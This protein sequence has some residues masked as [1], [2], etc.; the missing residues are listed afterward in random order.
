MAGLVPQDTTGAAPDSATSIQSD[1]TARNTEI[2]GGPQAEQDVTAAADSLA[3]QVLDTAS[4]FAERPGQESDTIAQPDSTQTAVPDSIQL[5]IFDP[6]GE[7]LYGIKAELSEV[8]GWLAVIE[9]LADVLRRRLGEPSEEIEASAGA[10]A[11]LS[12]SPEAIAAYDQARLHLFAARWAQAIRAARAATRHDST[13]AAAYQVQAEAYAMVGQRARARAMLEAAYQ[14]RRR[15]PERERFRIQADRLAWEGKEEAAMVAYEELF[16]R[17][18]DDVGALKSQALLQ[19]MVGVRGGGIGNLRVAYEI[20][21]LDWPP[22]ARIA[23]YLGYRGRL[24]DVDS[25][26]ANLQVSEATAADP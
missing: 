19:W 17:Y 16:Q 1:S 14:A 21:D 26:V 10:G 25:L 9:E 3:G 2:E 22:L 13:F 23:R 6:A 11:V 18:R 12:L 7:E 4:T 24:P 20:D 8:T 15:A 5:S